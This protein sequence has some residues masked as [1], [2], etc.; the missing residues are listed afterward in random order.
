MG[1]MSTG[2]NF[3]LPD[4]FPAI[5]S[6]FCYRPLP[7]PDSSDKLQEVADND[8]NILSPSKRKGKEPAPPE[9]TS[10]STPLENLKQRVSPSTGPWS[11]TFLDKADQLKL[12]SMLED[13]KKRRSK[14]MIQLKKGFKDPQCSPKVV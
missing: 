13:P 8:I 6:S 5:P 11:K 10:P 12:D 1:D 7:D 2:V 4:K 3:S 14:R 9:V